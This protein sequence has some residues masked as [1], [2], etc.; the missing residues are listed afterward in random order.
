MRDNRGYTRG[1]QKVRDRKEKETEEKEGKEE[2]EWKEEK[3]E[4][5]SEIDALIDEYTKGNLSARENLFIQLAKVKENKFAPLAKWLKKRRAEIHTKPL[6]P[7]E[8]M[9]QGEYFYYLGDIKGGLKLLEESIEDLITQNNYDPAVLTVYLTAY[10]AARGLD[11]GLIS[12]LSNMIKKN[13]DLRNQIIEWMT[14]MA[15]RGLDEGFISFLSNMIKKNTDLRNQIIEWITKAKLERTTTEKLMS[16]LFSNTDELER[17]ANTDPSAK[18]ILNKIYAFDKDRGFSPFVNKEKALTWHTQQ[19]KATDG[20]SQYILFQV[21]AAHLS[22]APPSQKKEIKEIA[23][24]WLH[25]AIEN[26]DPEAMAFCASEWL[27][28]SES[29]WILR[30]EKFLAD[31]TSM[32]LHWYHE[33]AKA[34]NSEYEYQLGCIYHKLFESKSSGSDFEK[35]I[36]WYKKA[37]DKGHPEACLALAK[38]Y[39]LRVSKGEGFS[40]LP[41]ASIV[42]G[43]G[44]MQG[45]A[46]MGSY[47]FR[48]ACLLPLKKEGYDEALRSLEY[49]MMA[50]P[51]LFTALN[52]AI[53]TRHLGLE[54]TPP[55]DYFLRFDSAFLRFEGGYRSHV[56]VYEDALN[57]REFSEEY[58][59]EILG[60]SLAKKVKSEML[61]VIA[62]RE[63]KNFRKGQSDSSMESSAK[64]V[65]SRE[66]PLLMG[67]I[68][69]YLEY[70]VPHFDSE[71]FSEEDK[72]RINEYINQLAKKEKADQEELDA[73]KSG[74][75]EKEEEKEETLERTDGTETRSIYVPVPFKDGPTVRARL[76]LQRDNILTSFFWSGNKTEINFEETFNEHT[77]NT[78]ANSLFDDFKLMLSVKSGAVMLF[79]YQI[80]EIKKNLPFI[81]YFALRGHQEFSTFL[82][83]NYKKL[84]DEYHCFDRRS[85]ELFQGLNLLNLMKK[86]A[87]TTGKDQT[88]A[89]HKLMGQLLDDKSSHAFEVFY[90]TIES[91]NELRTLLS[92]HIKQFFRQLYTSGELTKE[93]TRKE[94]RIGRLLDLHK[95][96]ENEY[97][98]RGKKVE[99][100]SRDFIEDSKNQPKPKAQA[101]AALFTAPSSDRSS[102]PS[103]WTPSATN[104]PK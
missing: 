95:K 5:T 57:F 84:K 65:L 58:L 71:G 81:I 101:P 55:Q 98:W 96:K 36:E 47:Y 70:D 73:Y 68:G 9:L 40:A 60:D 83:K 94:T 15:A 6:L 100:G 79:E 91:S 14:D 63:Y 26:R 64:H 49:F 52:R 45:Y 93:M 3:E 32:A 82:E 29:E 102:T 46:E 51:N 37:A 1:Y 44:S 30:E 89:F 18:K 34:G 72:A 4:S 80:R 99:T 87:T 31:N 39:Y 53:A 35:T 76:T 42:R 38:F 97:N 33:A 20:H 66:A 59:S 85:E 12:F 22:T 88:T 43:T 74:L 24:K 48:R 23:R 21:Y 54:Q 25:A 77:K 19:A 10:M 78:I 92:K 90:K 17:I 8:K 16:S 62:E 41:I 61:L 2:K 56:I 28:A 104:K 50:E 69:G 7:Y 86:V 13:T 27:R 75:K 103:S 11:E 67:L